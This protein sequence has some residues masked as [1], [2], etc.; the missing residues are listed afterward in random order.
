MLRAAGGIDKASLDLL[1]LQAMG[2]VLRKAVPEP[3]VKLVI[4]L[5]SMEREGRRVHDVHPVDL[6]VL[7][8]SARAGVQGVAFAFDELHSADV[9][10]AHNVHQR[11]THAPRDSDKVAIAR[12]GILRVQALHAPRGR[13]ELLEICAQKRSELRP[14]LLAILRQPQ[15]HHLGVTQALVLRL[16]A[17]VIIAH[18]PVRS[19]LRAARVAYRRGD[20]GALQLALLHLG[21]VVL[22]APEAAV[23]Q[24]DAVAARQRGAR[25]GERRTELRLATAA[26][27]GRLAGQASQQDHAGHDEHAKRALREPPAHPRPGRRHAARAAALG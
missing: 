13:P 15:L 12:T 10:L 19:A 18:K 25:G 23:P 26:H 22:P 8:R 3:S 14:R 27:G 16:L 20:N 24:V 6:V 21:E 1:L 9:L 17:G 5:G 7:R 2:V 11:A 4:L